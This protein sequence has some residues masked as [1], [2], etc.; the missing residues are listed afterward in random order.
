MANLGH[1]LEH[2]ELMDR[3]IC[4]LSYCL[5]E[6]QTFPRLHNLIVTGIFLPLNVMKI[7]CKRK[8]IGGRFVQ[9]LCTIDV[10]L[11]P[12]AGT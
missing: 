11:Y 1:E 8:Q 3:Q 10:F 4:L 9:F 2:I 7:N 12:P 6:V 5:D